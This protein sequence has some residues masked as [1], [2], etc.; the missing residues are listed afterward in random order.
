MESRH[1]GTRALLKQ[2]P[3]LNPPK[4]MAASN[5]LSAGNKHNLSDSPSQQHGLEGLPPSRTGVELLKATHDSECNP[6]EYRLYEGMMSAVH[7]TDQIMIYH[8]DNL[9]VLNKQA[10]HVVID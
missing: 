7:A 2:G 8:D 6:A 9:E 3:T 4:G 1:P 10:G 5:T